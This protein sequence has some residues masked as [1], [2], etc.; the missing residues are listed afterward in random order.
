MLSGDG[1][2]LLA[3]VTMF[4]GGATSNDLDASCDD[5]EDGSE[6]KL[7]GQVK[8]RRTASGLDEIRGECVTE[9]PRGV[10]RVF[11]YTEGIYTV[12]SKECNA[13]P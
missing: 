2:L 10:T 13:M 7:C 8:E 4:D 12:Y 5:V 11:P 9:N 6:D 3:I 1:T